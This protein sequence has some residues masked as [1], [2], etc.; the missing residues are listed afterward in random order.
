[1]FLEAIMEYGVPSRVRGDRGG[2]NRDVSILMTLVRGLNRASFMWGSSTFNT[3]AERLWVE[4]GS[5][6]A[7]SW[8]AFFQRLER[9]HLL[10]RL[11]AAH[12]W[13]IHYLFLGEINEDCNRFKDNWNSH[14]IS[15]EGHNQSPRVSVSLPHGGNVLML[16]Q[17]MWFL[18]QLEHGIYNDDWDDCEGMTPAEIEAGYGID[19]ETSRQNTIAQALDCQGMQINHEP[20]EISASRNPFSQAQ[21]RAFEELLS[22]MEEDSIV[23]LGYGVR[24][25]AGYVP[26][27]MIRSGIKGG[28]RE[29]RISLPFHLWHP[30]IIRWG[31]GMYAM[32]SVLRCEE[33]Q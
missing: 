22:G 23:P 12:L 18:G 9:D 29:L 3:R 25:S 16:Y 14:P 31:Q 21:K 17:D 10:E 15:G 6:F 26:Y 32:D 30:R 2:E 28:G 19:P 33:L 7:R 11:D 5:Q 8:R 24:H 13:L 4:V 27:E 1:M 20:V